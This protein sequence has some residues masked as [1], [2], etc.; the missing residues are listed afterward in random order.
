MATS[1]RA[2]AIACIGVVGS[3]VS[4]SFVFNDLLSDLPRAKKSKS[5]QD[6][7]NPL[8]VS[9]FPPDKRDALE[10]SFVLSSCL[11]IFEARIP[12]KTADQD[13]GLLQALDERL[14]T[15]GWLTNTGVKF[16]IVIDM[17][18]R[19]ITATDTKINT[20]IGLRD[21]DVKPVRPSFTRITMFLEYSNCF[22][23][24]KRYMQHTSIC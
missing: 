2:P 17:E 9:L 10:F 1:Q 14:A 6:Q 11:D 24:S 22:R 19:P 18:G 5:N 15:Y 23:L 13:F 7:N 4:F 20:T 3:A 16:I 12:H 21:S 8:H